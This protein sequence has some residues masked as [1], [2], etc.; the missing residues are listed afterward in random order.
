MTRS[1]TTAWLWNC[2]PITRMPITIWPMHF[3]NKDGSK[4]RSVNMKRL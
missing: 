2:D 1:S 3:G 4:K